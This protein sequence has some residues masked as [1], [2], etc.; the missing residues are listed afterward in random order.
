ME[1]QPQEGLQHP[2]D[3]YPRVNLSDVNDVKCLTWAINGGVYMLHDLPVL[4][5]HNDWKHM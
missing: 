4:T 5:G 1:Q 3:A 2:W